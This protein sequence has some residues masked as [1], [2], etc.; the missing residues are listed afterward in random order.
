[1]RLRGEHGGGA[2]AH[3][4]RT[5]LFAVLLLAPIVPPAFAQTFQE[6]DAFLAET[7]SQNVPTP[8][9]LDITSDMQR[10]IGRILRHSYR[11]QRL[12]YW[13]DGARTVWILEEIGRYRPITVGFVVSGGAIDTIRV[14]IYRESHGW[15]VR[16]DFFTN[17]FKGL[18]LDEQS[19]LSGRID[20]ISGATLSVNALRNLA[21]FALYLDRAVMASR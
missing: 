16:H 3:T 9:I 13:S 17:Q 14:L 1:M 20:G 11:A 6:P 5:L 4:A 15:E 21:R 19:N 8:Q 12:R 10:E 2:V 7:F 18:T